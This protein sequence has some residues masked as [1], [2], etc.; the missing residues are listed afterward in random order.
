[1]RVVITGG[2]TGIGKS[3]VESLSSIGMNIDLIYFSSHDEAIKLK[4]DNV[5]IHKVDVTDEEQIK[6][7][8]NKID[9]FD[10]LINN[11]GGNISFNSTD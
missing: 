4:S 9:S 3:C 6:Y 2:A 8:F 10:I 11:A 1:M 5:N 7:F